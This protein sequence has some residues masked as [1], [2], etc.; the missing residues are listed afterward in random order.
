MYRTA[1]A[2]TLISAAALAAC[3]TDSV[4]RPDVDIGAQTYATPVMDTPVYQ[5]APQEEVQQAYMPP[6]PDYIPPAP[7]ETAPAEPA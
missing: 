2:L 7:E 3:N 1:L 4:M 5:R 6:E